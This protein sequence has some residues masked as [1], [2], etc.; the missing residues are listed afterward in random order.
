MPYSKIAPSSS[1][2]RK[3]ELSNELRLLEW[4]LEAEKIT[5][6]STY[7]GKGPLAHAI[8]EIPNSKG[9]SFLF[10][11]GDFLLMDLKDPF[12]PSCL[13]KTEL[14]L[15]KKVLFKLFILRKLY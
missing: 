2:K 5:L 3:R 13:N 11:D 7:V 14:K 12:H 4:S 6:C 10:R 1:K 9:F 8:V 15:F